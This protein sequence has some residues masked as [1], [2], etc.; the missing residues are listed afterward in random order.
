[1]IHLLVDP[2]LAAITCSNHFL[3]DFISLS[4]LSGGILAHSYL[5]R[6]SSLLRFVGICLCTALATA[7]QSD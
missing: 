1:M 5:Q 4:H 2:I 6:C 7:F 3:Y